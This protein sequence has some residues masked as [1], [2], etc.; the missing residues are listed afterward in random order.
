MKVPF[1]P[2]MLEAAE[3]G[4]LPDIVIRSGI[5]QLLGQRV[6]TLEQA[7]PDAA[8]DELRAFLAMCR[9]SDI[10]ELPQRANEQHYEVPAEF[11]TQALGPRLKYSCCYFGDG[12]ESL[13]AAEEAALRSTCEHADLANGQRIL[14]L[15]CG[16]G[17]LSL[18]M[19]ENYPE[20]EIV[21]VSNSHGQR[22]FIEAQALARGCNNLTVQTADMNVFQAES[23]AF[24][25]VVSVEMFEHMRNHEEL[26]RRISTWL[27]TSGK[28]F[29][30]YFC[31]RAQPYLYLDEGPQDW[32]TRHFFAGGMMPSDHLLHHYQ[33][34]LRLVDQWRWGGRHYERTCNAWLERTD[35]RRAELLPIMEAT[36]GTGHG[37]RWLQRWRIFF[38][39]CAE[40]FGYRQGREWWVSHYLFEK[41]A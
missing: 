30:H 28:L 26:L 13:A 2:L 15:G 16:W 10:A 25:R 29:V 18:W 27:R 20:S 7:S 6:A 37:R 3:H 22:K 5:R 1:L 4:H 36:Y 23:A 21:A 41:P 8:Q 31:H 9:S 35:A 40:L 24:D 19:A 17:S 32:M 38:M 11:F 14:E 12:S 39:A 33:R 34:D